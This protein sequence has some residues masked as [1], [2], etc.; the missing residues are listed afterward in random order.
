MHIWN[1]KHKMILESL[2]RGPDARRGYWVD[3]W[4]GTL[5]SVWECLD[6]STYLEIYMG[7]ASFK[8]MFGGAAKKDMVTALDDEDF[9]ARWPLLNMLMVNNLDDDGKP[10]STCTMTIVCEH[11]VAKA[12][13]RE[14]NEGL[15]LW[16]TSETLLGVFDA[17]EEAVGASPPQW[18]KMPEKWLG[19]KR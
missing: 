6:H 5:T 17:L 19:G 11:G 3:P 1:R 10:R 4:T 2:M 14:R 18:R 12:G 9:L 7:K 13:L 16:V 8:Q 15:N